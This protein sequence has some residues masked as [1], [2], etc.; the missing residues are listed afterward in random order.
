MEVSNKQKKINILF[1]QG[2]NPIHLFGDV[3]LVRREPKCY[4]KLPIY[5]IKTIKGDPLDK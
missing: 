3:Y 2:Y 1:A 5:L 4:S